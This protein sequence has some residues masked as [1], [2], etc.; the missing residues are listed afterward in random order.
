MRI[1]SIIQILSRL[2][3]KKKQTNGYLHSS[4][5]SC[6]LPGDTFQSPGKNKGLVKIRQ[7]LVSRKRKRIDGYP[8]QVSRKSVLKRGAVGGVLTIVFALMLYFAGGSIM[9]SYLE[10]LTFFNVTEVTVSGNTMIPDEKVRNV[11]NIL[12][13]RTSLLGF[14]TSQAK[15]KLEEL[16]WIRKAVVTKNWPSMVEISITENVPSALMLKNDFD[17]PHLYYIDRKG[18]PFMKVEPGA[19]L[20]YPVV[21]G[22]SE[23]ADEITRETALGEVLTFLKALRSNNFHLPSQSVSEIHVEPNGEMVV[24]LV[25]YTFP[26]FFGNGNTRKKYSRLVYVLRD[27]YKK[28]KGQELIS[29]VEFIQMKYLDD[30]VLV[31]QSG[32]G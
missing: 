32:S 11:I 17:G 27:L 12:L 3:G 30:N 19:D 6:P 20:D 13:H 1:P 4:L 22:I 2:F 24:Y 26:I 5:R 10:S 29:K 18:L 15:G 23:V 16:P 21:T 14:S 31:A 25:E 8:R 9:H 28:K 7:W